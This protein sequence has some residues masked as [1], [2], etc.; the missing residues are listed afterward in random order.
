MCPDVIQEHHDGAHAGGVYRASMMPIF[1]IWPY[2][3]PSLS[4]PSRTAATKKALRLP[5]APSSLERA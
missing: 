4:G 3:M 1:F 2:V 5:A